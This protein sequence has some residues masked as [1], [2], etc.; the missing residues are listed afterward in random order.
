MD[1][2][3]GTWQP[4]VWCYKHLVGTAAVGV[5]VGGALGVLV[6]LVPATLGGIPR[7]FF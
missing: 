2:H 6:T 5:A 4:R 1:L 3:Q 7:V